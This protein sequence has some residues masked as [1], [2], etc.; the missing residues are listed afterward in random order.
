MRR[1]FDE[2]RRAAIADTVRAGQESGEF[3]A[4]ADA[5]S[6]AVTL[7][8]LLDGLA[9]QIALDDPDVPPARAYELVMRYAAGVL[10][11]TWAPKAGGPSRRAG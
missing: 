8:A 3:D 2:R 9:V 10:G 11:F 1:T 5:E 6:A 4:A 7:S